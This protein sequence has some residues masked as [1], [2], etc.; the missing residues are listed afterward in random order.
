MLD[1]VGKILRYISN[2]KLV[3]GKK[4]FVRE[5]RFFQQQQRRFA[6]IWISAVQRGIDDK[7]IRQD[8][9]APLI[10]MTLGIISTGMMDE[11][12]NNGPWLKSRKITPNEIIDLALQLLKIGLKNDITNK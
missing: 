3:E 12:A 4:N 6:K 7:T 9:S 2:P 10:A 1:L 11:I 5:I 8:L